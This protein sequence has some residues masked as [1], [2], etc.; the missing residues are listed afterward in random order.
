MFIT[1]EHGMSFHFFGLFKLLS[2]MFVIFS[3]G[4]LHVFC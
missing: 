2:A 4:V 3:E 1:H